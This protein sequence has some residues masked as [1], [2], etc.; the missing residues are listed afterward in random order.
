MIGAPGE[1]RTPDLLVRSQA[2]Y[3]TELRAHCLAPETGSVSRRGRAWYHI[4]KLLL[5]PPD[6]LGDTHEGV[7][8]Q[9]GEPSNVSG[10]ELVPEE[11]DDHG[12]DNRHDDPSR[13]E[14]CPGGG[15]AEQARN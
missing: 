2:L 4:T 11:Q 12:A 13:V 1:I 15:L 5:S 7:A 6:R 3:P 8:Q 10:H 14:W 9:N